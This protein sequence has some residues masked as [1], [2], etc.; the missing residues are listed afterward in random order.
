MSQ[1]LTGYD[2]TGSILEFDAD[3][4]IAAGGDKL[5]D[6][7]IVPF[8]R[9]LVK[10]E[11]KKG[12]F[13]LELGT[14]AAYSNNGGVFASR[15]SISDASG[16]TGYFEEGANYSF[17]Y[18]GLLMSNSE[19]FIESGDEIKIPIQTDRTVTEVE[20]PTHAHKMSILK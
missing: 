8:S 17:E 9:L 1:I 3:G 14:T 2:V 15:V 5:R 7:F 20:E 10:D 11:I 18:E 4:N 13:S 6:V 19:M 16:S 12:T